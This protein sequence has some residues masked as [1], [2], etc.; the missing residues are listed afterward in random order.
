M[1]NLATLANL[2]LKDQVDYPDK[3]V[4]QERKDPKVNLEHKEEMAHLVKQAYLE[5][6]ET[7]DLRVT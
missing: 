3:E 1:E 7:K 6:K 2:E 4:Q 5:K